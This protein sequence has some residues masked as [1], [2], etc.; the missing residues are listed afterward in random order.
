M[1]EYINFEESNLV[2]VRVDSTG[3]EGWWYEGGGI[4]RHVW[5]TVKE[6]VYLPEDGIYITA[7][8]VLE[9]CCAKVRIE[10]T[11]ANRRDN[12][13]LV[14]IRSVILDAVG[15]EICSTSTEMDICFWDENTVEQEM[16]L[17]DISLWGPENPYLYTCGPSLFMMGKLW[18]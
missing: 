14:C 2:A 4:Y 17:T 11:A 18:M 7:E 12:E 10:T 16:H 15:Q 6:P 8:P 3:R 13:I 9:T 5:L 1:T